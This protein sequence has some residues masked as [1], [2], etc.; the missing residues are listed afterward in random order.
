MMIANSA[1]VEPAPPES[2]ARPEVVVA[3]VVGP[4][5]GC[6]PAFGT[7]TQ[8]VPGSPPSTT[9]STAASAS[10]TAAGPCTRAPIACPSPRPTPAVGRSF[11][12]RN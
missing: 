10:T 5:E 7:A 6:A 12:R 4:P 8:T 2:P 9:A 3:V 11:R 1:S